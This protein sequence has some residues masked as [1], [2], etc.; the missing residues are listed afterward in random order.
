MGLEIKDPIT[1][2][3]TLLD[4]VTTE[5]SQQS[6]FFGLFNSNDPKSKFYVQYILEVYDDYQVSDYSLHLFKSSTLNSENNIFQVYEK[7]ANIRVGWIFPI[8]SLVSNEHN[9]KDNVHFLRYAYVAF[10]KLLINAENHKIHTPDS[11]PDG[12][13]EL[14]DFYG[15]D[16]IILTLCDAKWKSINNFNIENYIISLYEYGYYSCEPIDTIKQLPGRSAFLPVDGVK[17]LLQKIAPGLEKDVYLSRLFKSLL[18]TE[19]HPLIRFYLLYQVIELIIERILEKDFRALINNFSTSLNKKVFEL[20]DEIAKVTSEKERIS[21]L[22]HSMSGHMDANCKT[23][24]QLCC[25]DLLSSFGEDHKSDLA[26]SLYA[27]RGSIVHRFRSL[28]ESDIQK[29]ES[30]NREFEAILIDI[31]LNY[32]E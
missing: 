3:I 6:L 17:I 1:G 26:L 27:A 31:L 8:Q 5:V 29:I 30:I 9:Y 18:K 32:Q 16:L 23:N 22:V 21:K 11:N 4:Q 14:T 15:D 28:P 13:Y 10:L 20:K 19:E 25:N 24:L 7:D 2:Q 12:V